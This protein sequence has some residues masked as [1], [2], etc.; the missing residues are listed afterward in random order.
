MK[1]DFDL[2]DLYSRHTGKLSDKWEL[3]LS[4]YQQEFESYRQ[5]EI[6]FLE[7]GIQNGGSLQIWSEF[8][9]IA[10]S[11]IGCDI[12]L[13]CAQLEYEDNRISVVIGDASELDTQAK[14]FDISPTLDVV[15]DDGSHTSADI[16]KGFLRY[17]SSISDG[18]LYVAEDLHCSYWSEF[19]GGLYYPYSSM[20][21]FKR[22]ADVINHD[23]WGI[24]REPASV[25]SGFSEC[26]G[27][28]IEE[29][30]LEKVHSVKF[31]NSMC[32]IQKK[33]KA[34]NIL[35]KRWIAGDEEKV[36]K[37]HLALSG[38]FNEEFDQSDNYWSKVEIAP[39][40]QY[41]FLEKTLTHKSW[42][43]DTYR[44]ALNGKQLE[45]EAILKELTDRQESLL[46]SY[47]DIEKAQKITEKIQEEK[48][49][50]LSQKAYLES[51]VTALNSELGKK[52]W[53][54]RKILVKLRKISGRA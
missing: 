48:N 49:Q 31:V 46:K 53:L 52:Y 9:P 3:Y 34:N 13:N 22:I 33:A 32:F 8:F 44:D 28:A 50:L 21:F 4:A 20:A 12:D 45:A 18:G 30:L 39:D 25:L 43:S 42:E 41:E 6:N 11:L 26:Y 10:K 54:L 24:D 47:E 19:Q 2:K 40:E 38:V 35:G 15:I 27:V 16:I 36:V 51:Q 17:F 7:I 1:S 23:S 14:I 5:K 29:D 37:G